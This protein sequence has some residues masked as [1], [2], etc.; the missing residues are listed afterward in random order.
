MFATPIRTSRTSFFSVPSI[1]S[2]DAPAINSTYTTA[3]GSST[4]S[5]PSLGYPSMQDNASAGIWA[6]RGSATSSNTTTSVH[7]RERTNTSSAYIPR[8][9]PPVPGV[10]LSGTSSASSRFFP[11][12]TAGSNNSSSSMSSFYPADFAHS[13]PGSASG[14]GS[15]GSAYPNPARAGP[16]GSRPYTMAGYLGPS[17]SGGDGPAG[18]GSGSASGPSSSTYHGGPEYSSGPHSY[19]T[20]P[21]GNTSVLT[22]YRP[23]TSHETFSGANYSYPSSRSSFSTYGSAPGSG[24]YNS[25]AVQS[26]SSTATPYHHSAY[27]THPAYGAPT[28]A[29]PSGIQPEGYPSYQPPQTANSSSDPSST[30]SSGVPGYA[31]PTSGSYTYGSQPGVYPSS[32]IGQN[33]AGGP[34]SAAPGAYN[35]GFNHPAGPAIHYLNPFEVKHRRRTTKTQFRVLEGTFKENPKPNAAVRKALAQQL[36]MPGRAVQIWFQNRRAKAKAQAKKEE[37]TTRERAATSEGST[38]TTTSKA[39]Q[40]T[41]STTAPQPATGGSSS[42]DSYSTRS[43]ASHGNGAGAGASSGGGGSGDYHRHSQAQQPQGSAGYGS[44][45]QGHGHHG[46]SHH[47]SGGSGG[48]GGWHNSHMSS[49][50][51]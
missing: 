22:G 48:S 28:G 19:A 37:A 7:E 30:Y 5:S 34:V 21:Q 25:S 18:T 6:N 41:R 38:S 12:I 11:P 27:Q 10:D 24:S 44:Q 14:S 50:R 1:A 43:S 31:N 2:L 49:S 35:G 47:G 15:T 23:A 17:A 32:H 33:A 36:D 29:G 40:H 46:P 4:S 42:T 3:T 20:G 45:S 9:I 39:Q 13:A 16:E 26:S 51:N 8:S